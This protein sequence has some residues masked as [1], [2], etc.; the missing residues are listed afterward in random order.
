MSRGGRGARVL[1]SLLASASCLSSSPLPQ[2]SAGAVSAQPSDI[3]S[4]AAS[5]LARISAYDYALAGSFAGERSRIVTPDRYVDALAPDRN[6]VI[7]LKDTVLTAAFTDRRIAT[8]LVA[9][10]DAL[11]AVQADIA[12][13]DAADAASFAR[14]LDD[15]ATT[16]T[17]LADAARVVP[18]DALATSIARGTSWRVVVTRAPAFAV[19][20]QAFESYEEAVQIARQI[21][22]AESVSNAPPFT[23]RVLTTPDRDAAGRKVAELRAAGVVA[24][25]VDTDRYTFARSGPDPSAE[26]WREGAVDI[27]TWGEA[28][29]AAFIAN[30][31]VVVSADGETF[32]FDDTGRLWWHAKL[33]SG[34]TF[35]TPSTDGRYVLIGGLFVQLL[36]S[37]GQVIGSP[38]RLPSAAAGAVWLGRRRVFVAAS[39]GPTGKPQGGGGGVVALGLNGAPLDNPFP[40]VTP[41]AG[42]ALATAPARDDVLIATT[43][44]GTTDVEA[45]R[46]GLDQRVRAV[47]RVPGQVS[48]LAVDEDGAH[49][50]VVTAEGTYRFAPGGSNPAATLE[51]LAEPARDVA[52][53][54]DGALYLLFDRRL[55][56]YDRGLRT[57]WTVPLRD[58]RRVVAARRIIVQDGLTRVLAVDAATGSGD[59]L[60]PVGELNDI[61]ASQDGARILLLADGQRAV[62]FHLP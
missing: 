22:N 21:A 37:E 29:R 35:A 19:Q 44:N 50:I 59:E 27:P 1:F 4:S 52:F 53:G 25:V 12:S 43:S 7:A 24:A 14:V 48:D 8:P 31:V 42:P 60:A 39:Q 5:V 45:I 46:P 11:V 9:V 55:V 41:A 38:S 58:G 23:V 6:A 20:T 36:G 26:L 3:L 32:S 16:W 62:I 49:V 56:A 33:A 30:G 51:R 10:A 61:A 57:L 17:A 54:R 15:V 18:G 2:P 34:P 47:V 13:V 40:L 28:R